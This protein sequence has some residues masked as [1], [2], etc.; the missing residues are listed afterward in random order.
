[1]VGGVAEA[2]VTAAMT[3]ATVVGAAEVVTVVAA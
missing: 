1:M 3:V 2:I